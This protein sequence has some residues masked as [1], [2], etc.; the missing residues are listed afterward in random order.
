[1]KQLRWRQII[2]TIRADR[3]SGGGLSRAGI[4]AVLL[5][6][7]LSPVPTVM[8]IPDEE[9]FADIDQRPD[10]FLKGEPQSVDL[11]YFHS[12]TCSSCNR[13]SPLV[14]AFTEKYPEVRLYS[15]EIGLNRTNHEIFQETIRKREIGSYLIPLFIIGNATLSGEMEIRRFL[16]AYLYDERDLTS[17]IS[18]QAIQPI[19]WTYD[20]PSG[21]TEGT[22]NL[23]APDSGS[24]G[25]L[26]VTVLSVLAAAAV[27]S[28]NPCAFAVLFVLLAYLTSLHNRRR[29]LQVGLTYIGVVFAVYLVAGLA[30]LGFVHSLGISEWVSTIAALVVI[31]AGFIQ[32][33]DLVLKQNGFT[34]SIPEA[35]KEKISRNIRR[36]TIPSAVALG[37]LV[38]LVELPCTGG[39]YLA[40]LGLI[41]DR[42]TFAEG[43]P[44]LILYNII[45]VL[46]LVIALGIVY[47][48]TS[49]DR[50]EA[51][52]YR[53]N[54]PVRL[55]IG[56]FM[57]GIGASMLLG[58]V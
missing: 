53:Y 57:I 16:E 13:V 24:S 5:L 10:L 29:L 21:G 43:L 52:R 48:G 39:I 33:V 3:R 58:I 20:H 28:I 1:M 6:L 34:L 4:I 37:T 11:V 41:S 2:P 30:L 35:A 40:I 46:P 23:T 32:I 49:P 22:G 47:S 38:S 55:V 14:Y 19:P 31:G 25:R 7:L 54:R 42:M 51:L 36:A 9:N 15:Y 50:V 45:F 44:Y 56:I 17:D 18:D 12:V 27:D 26:E 8:G